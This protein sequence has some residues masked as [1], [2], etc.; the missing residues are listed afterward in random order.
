MRLAVDSGPVGREGDE[1]EAR[2]QHRVRAVV[3]VG[4]LLLLL[5]GEKTIPFVRRLMFARECICILCV[6]V[7]AR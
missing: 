5:A 4:V 6:C 7:R 3:R 2:G 1:R